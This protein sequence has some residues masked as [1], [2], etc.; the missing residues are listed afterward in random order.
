MKYIYSVSLFLLF[1]T[2]SLSQ[3]T[4]LVFRDYNLNGKRDSSAVYFEP[5]ESNFLV[6]LTDRFGNT[7]NTR[8]LENGQFSFVP[9]H[10]QP[11]RIEFIPE[12]NMDFSG[13]INITGSSTLVQFI[14]EDQTQITFGINYP[15]DHCQNAK[16]MTP[17]YVIGDPLS[18]T[19][20][21]KDLE[22]F[23]AWDAANGGNNFNTIVPQMHG[24][25][26]QNLSKIA[27]AEEIGSCW[28]LAYQ[29]QSNTVI[30]SSVLKRH[31]GM[32]PEGN[33]GLYFLN[34]TNNTVISSLDLNS[35][36]VPSGFFPNNV[37]RQL[38][39]NYPPISADSLAFAM[40]AK[41]AYGGMELSE[42]GKTLYIISLHTKKLYSIFIDNPFRLPTHADVDSFLIP[43][44]PCQLG[45]FRPWAL[46][47]RRGKLY[48][49]GLCDASF[50][51]ANSSNLIANVQEFNP[52][53]KVFTSV[54]DFSFDYNI[55]PGNP[56][57]FPWIDV[58]DP[59][60]A[61][62]PAELFQYPQPIITDIEFD[63]DDFMMLGITDR[64]S[65]QAGVNQKNT[66]GFGTFSVLSLG[67]IL[68]ASYNT[69]SGKY[70]L[71]NN[72]SDGVTQTNGKN[73][74]FGP[75]GGEYYYGDNAVDIALNSIEPESLSGGLALC[76]G[77]K[78][79]ISTCA[80]VFDSY[81][82]GVVHLNNQIGSW[83]KRYQIIPADFTLFL[84][85]SNALGDLKLSSQA[86]SIEIGNYVWKDLNGN[87]TQDP[88][89]PPLANVTLELVYQ[90]V[91]IATAV[92]NE[93]GQYLFSNASG[94]LNNPDPA[95]FIYGISE[96]I[97]NENYLIRI[98][99]ISN[100]VATTNLSATIPPGVDPNLFEVDNNGILSANDLVANVTTG[101]HGQND[102]SFDFG[103][104]S[105]INGE[106]FDP[107]FTASACDGVLGSFDLHIHVEL[108]NG[109]VGDLMVALSTGEKRRIPGKTNGAINY[110]IRNLEAKGIQ[111]VSAK[112]YYINDTTIIAELADA[113][114]QPDPCC[115]N[116]YQICSN[117]ENIV[118]LSA[119]AGYQHYCWYVQS[120][121]TIISKLRNLPI[122]KTSPGLEDDFESYYFIAIDSLG[123]TLFQ[124][125]TFDISIVECC[126]LQI[127]NKLQTDCNNNGTLY[128]LDDDWFAVLLTAE[129]TDA[130]PSSQYEIYYDNQLLETAPYGAPIIA[131]TSI[132]PP[133]RAD[134]I[135][136]YKLIIRDVD[137]ATC[138]DS[139]VTVVSSCPAPKVTLQKELLNNI[140]QSDG[141]YNITYRITI[142]NE[143][144]DIGF[145]NLI[146][147]PGFDNDIDVNSAFYST[148]IPGKGGA[149]LIGSGPWTIVS[150]QLIQAGTTHVVNVI[151]NLKVDL[152]LNSP[153]DHIYTKCQSLLSN[154]SS[155]GEGLFNRALL[156]LGADGSIDLIDTSCTDIA[157]I[158]LDKV[159]LGS[160]QISTKNHRLDYRIIVRNLGGE[161]GNYNLL[162][163][164]GFDD[165]ISIDSARVSSNYGLQ[166]ILT[167]S[168]P[169][170]GWIIDQN[171][172]ID[173]LEIDSFLIT[174]FTT[175]DFDA[176][177]V[178]NNTYRPCGF[179]N[180]NV[181]RI[182]EGLFNV[183]MLDLNNDLR[184]ERRDTVCD[185]LS[186][187][188]H[189][190]TITDQEYHPDGTKSIEYT[191][192]VKNEGGKPANY[193]LW[194]KPQFDNDVEILTANYTLNNASSLSL[195][196]APGL[197]GWQ[198]TQNRNING[199]TND[200]FKIQLHLGLNFSDSSLGDKVFNNCNTD[201]NGQFIAGN[202]LFNESI[203][204]L[205]ADGLIDQKDTVCSNFDY[206]DLALR[207]VSLN[208]N[209]V[210]N[211]ANA[212]FRI[213][214][215]N[216]GN[217]TARQITITDY[218]TKAYSFN[219]TFNP[220]WV[221]INDSTL[222]YEIAELVS[223]DSAIID[224]ILQ[225]TAYIQ[226]HPFDINVSEIASFYTNELQPTIDIDSWPD[227]ERMNDNIPIPMSPEDDLTTGRKKFNILDDEDD[228]DIATTSFFDMALKKVLI[229][230][231]PYRYN[232]T[233]SFKITVYNQGNVASS[234][235]DIVDYI[236]SGYIFDSS[237]NPGWTLHGTNAHLTYTQAILPKDSAEIFIHLKFIAT[238]HPKN[239]INE[240]ELS[241]S[242]IKYFHLIYFV[243]SD[244]DSQPD[245]IKGND[246]GGIVKSSSDDHIHDDRNDY[247]QDGIAD[248]D[249]H[250]PAVPFVWDLALTKYL[251]TAAPHYPGQN[252]EFK[253]TIHNQ[254][255]DTVGQVGIIDY[256]TLGY[257][258]N[259][260]LNP[261]W[262]QNGKFLEY[263]LV[264]KI[265][266]GDSASVSLF[267]VLQAGKR[268]Q[269]D[270]INYAEIINSSDHN[271]NDRTGFDLDSE[272]GSD[273]DEERSVLPGEI[274]DNNTAR[275][276]I[277][278][279]EDDHDPASAEIFDLALRKIIISPSPIKYG[280]EI[281]FRIN[282][283][284]QGYIAASEIQIV[285]Y[286]PQ[287]LDFI[288][289]PG[290]TFNSI[291]RK[292]YY[293]W[294]G[295]L[296]PGDS[297]HVFIK[298][299]VHST[300]GGGKNMTNY[301]EISSARDYAF[302]IYTRDID[303]F[304]DD[305]PNNDAG[306]IPH[307]ISDNHIDDDSN[308]SDLNGIRDEDDHDP[309][310]VPLVDFALIKEILTPNAVATGDTVLFKIIVC[311]QGNVT[312][313]KL[314]I[315]DYVN[316]AYLFPLQQF[317]GWSYNAQ[318]NM[319]YVFQN[320]ILPGQSDSVYLRLLI[321][322]VN[323][324]SDLY[325]YAE[326]LRA[327]DTLNQEIS[328]LDAD[329]QPGSNTTREREV[330][331]THFW[332]N[333]KN[334]GGVAVLQDEDDHDVAGVFGVAK[335][336]DMVWHDKNGNGLM[337]QGEEGIKDIIVQ[338]Y[339]FTSLSLVKATVTNSNGK[340]L[341]DNIVPGKYY[342]RFVV[343]NPWTITTSNVGTNKTIDS[344]VNAAFG[345]GTTQ[346]I[347]LNPGTEDLSW[348]LGLYK[349]VQ[350]SG[351]VFYDNN[352]DG[353]RLPTESG[354]NGLMIY[355]YDAV[356]NNLVTTTRTVYDAKEPVFHDG[357]Y[358]FCVKP[359]TY[360]IRVHALT[361]FVVTLFQRGTDKSIDS[362]LSQQFGPFTSIPVVGNS[363]DT[364]RHLGGGVY[365][366]TWVK[367]EKDP[368]EKWVSNEEENEIILH[369]DSQYE[370]KKMEFMLYPNPAEKLIHYRLNGIDHCN[371]SIQVLDLLGKKMKTVNVI[372]GSLYQEQTLD[373]DGIPSGTYILQIKCN[374]KTFQK[375][376]IK[377]F[378]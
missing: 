60:W 189:Q 52:I 38:P 81:T 330:I 217:Q 101:M 295:L 18:P 74:G 216:Q 299:K 67:D 88:I 34:P 58:W 324:S 146:D 2:F 98:P 306:G 212:I 317:S 296:E 77:S 375:M 28:G 37:G 354:I 197:T 243:Q 339:S 198:L 97:E 129:N 150:N 312:S 121:G 268:T 99:S 200:S 66:S 103:F 311:N 210:S 196:T 280:E 9:S 364:I 348:D 342:V 40:V 265:N 345:P 297:T 245:S 182:G 126:A 215:F 175:M 59:S 116:A 278:G 310:V 371:Y 366:P 192:T 179:T 4:G 31:A 89:E 91:V 259:A 135:S 172:S 338:L 367:F 130:G 344:D 158:V 207:K 326:I 213:T 177:S 48:I 231:P 93:N 41:I 228:L 357:N 315:I 16:I 71:E 303:S 53:T 248:E 106:V 329:S 362:D 302:R 94:P 298:L 51:G 87:G 167:S 267:L 370:S 160:Q 337:D 50:P 321:G 352:K 343:P 261:G 191:I 90:G 164:P 202:G 256:L 308:D 178:G 105:S 325:N 333:V 285:D 154:R 244:L 319:E 276:G 190:K 113:F 188:I 21:F 223:G 294:N 221:Q 125:C 184:P 111:D 361:G 230:P 316:S 136:T 289:Q 266:P 44:L 351:A 283:F 226:D 120:T 100:Q 65:L 64:I 205:N 157:H 171:K 102:H 10:S 229:T 369:L 225:A 107:L 123:D 6:K 236:P 83:E 159:F 5:G 12:K 114:D 327:S 284:N 376:F 195:P 173:A 85:K 341:F 219:S 363:C 374:E 69:I 304:F 17:C 241:Q 119:P 318:N 80:D 313:S 257:T 252:L 368:I 75:G 117:R 149:A 82:N 373:L 170:L 239:W 314:T 292:A 359:G 263:D 264:E 206:Y 307:T 240:A 323:N 222:S 169:L 301:S 199:L 309:A 145:Y 20:D 95:A 137:D 143:G 336:G 49:G 128:N 204:D 253:I 25:S 335:L 26:A 260:V 166:N 30:T 27:T 193:S 273:S 249:D 15:E 350:I 305:D 232:D 288:S 270:Y 152:N 151:F 54:L 180:P 168:V 201:V 255:T 11:Y 353:V 140:I 269:D 115:D 79:V 138:I 320:P 33:G 147:E 300:Y 108:S 322:H 132:N 14:Y 181:A 194:D 328:Q 86:A 347:M 56:R 233:L 131:G 63:G 224:L 287:G 92:T 161:A 274:D 237:I 42:D 23:V 214:V 271:G 118:E 185:D 282:L 331:P 165:D 153:S 162:D 262:S 208:I 144:N 258:F 1:A 32:G 110:T 13:P 61:Q 127:T 279:K 275:N 227:F 272:E 209:P 378:K 250:D 55:I 377:S 68:R 134:G 124:Y 349:C 163:R 142:K 218:L 133:F 155:R 39:Q 355:L 78:Q 277:D 156:D 3:V 290:W 346:M 356:T 365:N 148:T 139:V 76:P 220:N 36:G 203:L 234:K 293:T 84:G 254:G 358:K 281:E 247:N 291:T 104:Y 286:L 360:Y 251:N 187:I 372:Q 340:Y 96:I 62:A 141:S 235:V 109:P 46:K 242:Y 47:Q 45:E 72:A 238:D 57:F 211:G 183:A 112:I 176:S 332:D 43:A 22:A 7:L 35:I 186:Q 19:S 174:I 29:R 122:Y 334:G 8:T 24:G 246:I 70:E 73:T